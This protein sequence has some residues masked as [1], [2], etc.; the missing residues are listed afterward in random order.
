MLFSRHFLPFI[1]VLTLHVAAQTTSEPI[2]SEP[3]TSLDPTPTSE[4]ET[5]ITPAPESGAI[6]TTTTPAPE[7]TAIPPEGG[8][9]SC[10]QGCLVRAAAEVGCKSITDFT[11]VCASSG[12]LQEARSCFS[13]FSCQSSAVGAAVKDYNTACN[14]NSESPVITSGAVTT[15]SGSA[16]TVTSRFTS[17][18][19]KPSG[20]LNGSNNGALSAKWGAT[21]GIVGLGVVAGVAVLAL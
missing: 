7:S 3:I 9:A 12:Y 20:S 17:P 11:C 5:S 1:L 18:T 4:P 19:S 15:V 2:E 21:G 13:E 8:G 14:V 10:V 16:R 6:S